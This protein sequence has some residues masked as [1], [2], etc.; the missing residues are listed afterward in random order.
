MQDK[1]QKQCK[2]LELLIKTKDKIHRSEW[3]EIRLS[4]SMRGDERGPRSKSETERIEIIRKNE[5]VQQLTA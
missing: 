4:T 2:I 3:M 1:A 5:E